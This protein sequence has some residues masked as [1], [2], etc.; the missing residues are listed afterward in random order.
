VSLGQPIFVS[1]PLV[2]QSASVFGSELAF[3]DMLGYD[4]SKLFPLLP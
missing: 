4:E 1:S 2:G 3:L